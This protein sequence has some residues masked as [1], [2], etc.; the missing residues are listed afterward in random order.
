MNDGVTGRANR[1]EVMDWINLVTAPNRGDRYDVVNMDEPVSYVTEF[2]SE[3]H[4]ADFALVAMMSDACCA[5]QG[6]AFVGVYDNS[7]PGTFR[8]GAGDRYRWDT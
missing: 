2:S 4:A 6:I 3:I 7:A 5:C 8:E 1:D